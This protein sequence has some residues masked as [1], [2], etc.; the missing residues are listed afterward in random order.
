MTAISASPLVARESALA[1][2]IVFDG[3]CVLCSAW[4]AFAL[5]HGAHRRFRFATTQS[6]AG[7][8]LLAAN[9]IESANP[10]TFLFVEAGGIYTESDA[11]I[12]MLWTLGGM[13]RWG[14]GARDSQSPA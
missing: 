7:R 4:V 13:W 11:V 3:T 2:L 10:S 9:G 1:P 5:R 8:A 6:S 14:S 12:R